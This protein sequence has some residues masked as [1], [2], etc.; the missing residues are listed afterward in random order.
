MSEGILYGDYYL[1]GRLAA[2][3]MA[4][5]YLGKSLTPKE[6]GQLLAIKRMLPR[7][8]EDLTFVSMF[9]DEARIASSLSHPNICRLFDEGQH[10]NQLYL[11]MEFI[12]GKD[13][14]V[15][16]RRSRKRGEPVP[17]RIVA[18]VAAKIAEALEYAHT[19]TDDA[20]QPQSIVHRDVSPQNILLSYDGSP[21]LID[22]GI[23]KAKDRL[24]Q[25][26]VGVVKGK[27][28]YMSPEQATGMPLDHR[29]DIFSLGVVLYE[30]LTGQ[31]PFKG[32]SDLS[33]LKRIARAECA[34]PRELNDTI[35]ARL[36][37]VVTRAMSRE[38]DDRYATAG[39]MAI[40]LHRHLADER[41]ELTESV[42]SSYM[43]R[44]FRDDYIGEMARIKAFNAVVPPKQTAALQAS[45]SRRTSDTVAAPSQ[46]LAAGYDDVPSDP[47]APEDSQL[48]FDTREL[49]DAIVTLAEKEIADAVEIEA[50][51]D[52]TQATKPGDWDRAPGTDEVANPFDEPEELSADEFEPLEVEADEVESIDDDPVKPTITEPNPVLDPGPSDFSDDAS[53]HF[54]AKTVEYRIPVEALISGEH[55]EFDEEKPTSTLKPTEIGDLLAHAQIV[56]ELDP[57]PAED[58]VVPTGEQDGIGTQ[59]LTD[60]EVDSMVEAAQAHDEE[61]EVIDSFEAVPIDEDFDDIASGV[62]E[63]PPEDT[64]VGDDF[65]IDIEGDEEEGEGEG[66]EE[67]EGEG[68]A[69]AATV[70]EGSGSSKLG[71]TDP[72]PVDSIDSDA[73]SISGRRLL[74]AT[75]IAI[76]VLAAALG[77]ALVVGAY[78]YAMG[79]LPFGVI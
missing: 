47:G 17:F 8:S 42:L 10:E 2:G 49:D 52:K 73:R 36:A 54:G 51:D 1:L 15:V 27:F 22:F 72:G 55:N 29:A 6:S 23:A 61:E 46:F 77:T 79:E 7:L 24:V 63:I 31:L 44:L 9:M 26:R 64:D 48:R 39:E 14:R 56:S 60:D 3:G 59:P 58:G 4:E 70:L 78:L 53:G 32:S 68:I 76:L 50:F 41:R 69:E 37:S 57:E 13:L 74:T 18:F 38:P 75:E 43:R 62:M 45:K 20:D 11:A 33:T 16:R 21:K 66:E 34:P 25:T 5:V 71:G 67:G 65:D 19:L 12:H 40:D 28:T 30:L 35:P